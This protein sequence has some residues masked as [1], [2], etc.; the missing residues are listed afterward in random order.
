MPTAYPFIAIEG[1]I[2]A[3]KTTL[4]RII[5]E[6]LP[7]SVLLEVFEENPFLGD[8]YADRVRYAFQTQ[9]FF[10]LSRYRQQHKVVT[11]TLARGPLVSDYLFA[12]D[13]LFAHLNLAGDE[14]AMYERVH[15]ILGE[16][17]TVPSLVIFLR[18]TT[19]TLMDRIAVR[20]RP[21]RATDVAGLYRCAA[22][23]IRVVFHGVH[24]RARSAGGNRAARLRA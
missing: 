18:A 6:S 1:A 23:R 9:V 19:D 4:A 24:H 2:G 17:L 16:K 10:L 13:W 8:F 3:G 21:V 15:G 12:K 20:D 11:E 5:G 14:L 22:R 7:A